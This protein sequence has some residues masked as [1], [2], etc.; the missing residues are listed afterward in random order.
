[1]SDKG[2]WFHGRFVYEGRLRPASQTPRLRRFSGPMGSRSPHA[3]GLTP[4]RMAEDGGTLYVGIERQNEIVCFDYGKEGLLARGQP[5]P[6]PPVF[7][8]FRTTRVSRP[9]SSFPKG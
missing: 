6:V 5:V 2:R 8:R 4:N 3:A 1:M 9:W 7:K